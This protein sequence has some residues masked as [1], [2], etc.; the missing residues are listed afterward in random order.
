MM[1]SES[2]MRL[3]FILSQG[4]LLGMTRF[5]DLAIVGFSGWAAYGLRHKD[6]LTPGHYIVAIIIILAFTANSFQFAGLY[7]SNML[8]RIA[9]PVARIT[10]AW[11]VVVLMLLA[12]AFFSKTSADY[13]RIWL[14]TWLWLSYGLLVTSRI[15][16]AWVVK[17]VRRA[18]YLH[19]RLIIVGTGE[20][21]E[22]AIGH[23]TDLGLQDGTE[24]DSIYTDLQTV[25]KDSVA[26]KPVVGT[27]DDLILR[28][29]TDTN[30]QIVL[31]LPWTAT[32]RIHRALHRLREAP[33]DV[34]LAPEPIG[35]QMLDRRVTYWGGVPMTNVQDRPLSGWNYIIKSLEDRVL[36][37]IILVLI[38]PVLL[39]VAI[40][41][42]LDSPGP[43]IFRQR[44]SGFNNNTFTVY[45]FRSMRND[46]VDDKDVKQASRGDARIT[47]VGAFI[48]K[49][50]LDELPQV[51]NVLQGDMS[52]VGPR[53]HAL[54]HNEH[55]AGVIDQYLS[56]HKVKPGITGWAQ[57]HGLRGETETPDKMAKR[58]QYDLY[59]IDNWSLMLDIRILFMTI[60][61]GFVG[62]NAY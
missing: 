2:N 28:L 1:Q 18:G 20:P 36:A 33:V 41:I 15:L 13:S 30:A 50:S 51:F 21:V 58:V 38:A 57:V 25:E 5:M 56:R 7:R 17:R 37:A 24:I 53:P 19:R 46:P 10:I 6:W 27:M 14:A 55:Y 26:G 59:Y 23:M 31:A 3:G 8:G 54:A 47:R 12:V 48:R 42:K 4:V 45:K 40:A 16:W 32:D 29:R 34:R 9:E 11:A 43:V 62:Q 22:R 60:F 35:Y 44:R 49:T 52:L 61:V 39:A